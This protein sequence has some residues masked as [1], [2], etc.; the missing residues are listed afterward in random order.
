QDSHLRFYC[1]YCNLLTGH[2]IHLIN[3]GPFAWLKASCLKEYHFTQLTWSEAQS[4]CR[5]HHN[6]LASIRSE[7]E[8]STIQ[9][10]LTATRLQKV[11]IGLYRDPWAFWSDNSTS[12]FTNW[13]TGQPNNYGSKQFHG[14][15]SLVSG[16]WD[17]SENSQRQP[18]FCYKGE[19]E[20]A[21]AVSCHCHVKC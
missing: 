11:W 9:S 4:Y 17:D 14:R 5:Q 2:I 7:E 8:K 18:F 6:D 19:V 16:K 1:L 10:T 21:S 13:G 15:F 20:N 12:T 3:T